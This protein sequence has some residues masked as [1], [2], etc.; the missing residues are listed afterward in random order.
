MALFVKCTS[1]GDIVPG[2]AVGAGL[3]GRKHLRPV[4]CCFPQVKLP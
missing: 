4:S 1:A 3:S 2:V